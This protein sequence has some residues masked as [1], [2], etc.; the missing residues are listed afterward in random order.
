MPE[1]NPDN[2]T[3]TQ[4]GEDY[5]EWVNQYLDAGAFDQLQQPVLPPSG[6][7]WEAWEESQPGIQF[8][9]NLVSPWVESEDFNSW[10]VDY[11]N[12]FAQD[13]Q[14]GPSS[15]DRTQRLGDISTKQ[16]IDTTNL[17]INTATTQ[18]GITGFAGSGAQ[19][20]ILQ[21]LWSNYI[22]QSDAINLQTEQS[23]TDIY[24]S[25][26]ESILDTL[27][28]LGDAGAFTDFEA[29]TLGEYQNDIPEE[30]AWENVNCSCYQDVVASDGSTVSAYA[31]DG[32]CYVPIQNPD[33]TFTGSYNLQGTCP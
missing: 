8:W 32:G 26:G 25:Q 19:Q 3:S 27:E 11:G 9:Q 18:G 14:L 2:Y 13:Y 23:T 17:S 15:L 33:G 20:N 28:Q 5:Y 31:G 24:Q 12:T 22:T 30:E 16:L 1:Y 10:W 6:S 21:D 29:T 7:D 4:I